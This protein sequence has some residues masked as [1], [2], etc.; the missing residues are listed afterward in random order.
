[1]NQVNLS[2]FLWKPQSVHW[3]QRAKRKRERCLCRGRCIV[4]TDGNIDAC[5][6]CAAGAEQEYRVM[7]KARNE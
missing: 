1:V 6:A 2:D 5:P 3:R 4:I 7:E